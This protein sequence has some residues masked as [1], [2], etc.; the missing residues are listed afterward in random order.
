MILIQ[1]IIGNKTEEN[2]T[3]SSNVNIGDYDYKEYKTIK[4]LH[5]K[6]G[7]VE[8]INLALAPK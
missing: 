7:E 3:D 8:E 6:T 1:K 2:K 5:S 4:L